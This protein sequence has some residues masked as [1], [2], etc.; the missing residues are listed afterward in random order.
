M[1]VEC[2]GGAD[3]WLA[4][5]LVAQSV[6][7]HRLPPR[8]ELCP[9]RDF[10]LAACSWRSEG[11]FGPSLS[12]ALPVQALRGLSCLG[13]L[14]RPTLLGCFAHQAC[15]GGPLTGV[16]LC[17]SA[18]QA[19]KGAPWVGSYSVVQCLSRL[20][21]QP[22][23]SAAYAGMR[24]ERLWWWL[25]PLR[26]T[27]QYHLASMAAWLSSTGDFPSRSHP[28]PPLVLSLHS[29]QQPSHWDCSTIPKHQLPATAPSRRPAFLPSMCMAVAS[30][31]WFSLH[32]GC[33]RSAVS[34]SAF[35][36]SP[37][38]QTIAPLWGSAQAQFSDWF[39]VR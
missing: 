11:L 39:M 2:E 26:V 32:L 21:G 33:H 17:R 7:G 29:Q 15:S 14:P 16:L 24:R 20:V 38:T 37:L 28:S 22:V 27:Q 19:L 36:V 10:F 34:G 18:H 8:Q 25:H 35:N 9:I 13:A 6:Q 3:A 31:V 1:R 12:I 30:A 23:C 5:T 4:G